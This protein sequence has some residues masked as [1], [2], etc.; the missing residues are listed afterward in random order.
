MYIYYPF[1]KK[2]HSYKQGFSLVEVLVA[3]FIIT[4]TIIA[5]T[6]A[7]TK[8]IQ[9]SAQ[10]LRQTQVNFLLEEGAEAVKTIR[11]ANWGTIAALTLDTPYYLSYS[12][13]TNTWSLSTTTIPAIDS[14]FTRT[15]T[16]SSVYRDTNDDIQ[17]SGTLDSRTIKVTV[18][19][20]WA[21]SSNGTLSKNLQFYMSDIFN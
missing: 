16:F 3:C 7:T 6:S 17:S 5:V 2:K 1:R 18:T 10:A 4:L 8:G 15:V 19:T 14:I 11:D 13:S 20:S 9:L 21:T 12:T